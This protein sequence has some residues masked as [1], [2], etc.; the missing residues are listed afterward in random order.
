MEDTM[1][2]ERISK[3]RHFTTLCISGLSVEEMHQIL[4]VSHDALGEIMKNHGYG[5]TYTCW[6]NGYGIYSIRHVGGHL[7]VEIGNSCD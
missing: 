1:K 4:D 5:D 3:D 6:H 2:I 7:F